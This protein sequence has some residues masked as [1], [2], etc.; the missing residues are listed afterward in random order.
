MLVAVLPCKLGPQIESEGH[1]CKG[2]LP[3]ALAKVSHLTS[4]HFPALHFRITNKVEP[5]KCWWHKDSF[6]DFLTTLILTM[7][8]VAFAMS[9]LL[10]HLAYHK[11]NDAELELE[12]AA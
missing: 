11:V 9:L 12:I 4:F 5:T 1:V 3:P 2:E 10:R 6:N 7:A 8:N